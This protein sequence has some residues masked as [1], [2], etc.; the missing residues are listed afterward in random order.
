MIR[1]KTLASRK[2]DQQLC[3]ST[4]QPSSLWGTTS[5][6]IY[7]LQTMSVNY[8]S[9]VTIEKRITNFN[10]NSIGLMSCEAWQYWTYVAGMMDGSAVNFAFVS[11]WLNDQHQQPNEYYLFAHLDVSSVLLGIF[12]T[13]LVHHLVSS[14]KPFCNTWVE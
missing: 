10:G 1:T 4:Y 8:M 9:H 12:G 11:A 2:A 3:T 13:C 7:P 6:T 5:C 14:R